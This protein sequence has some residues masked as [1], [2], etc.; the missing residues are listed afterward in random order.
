VQ[1]AIIGLG[2]VGGSI[3]LALKRSG[4][5]GCEVVGYVRRPEVAPTALR[6]GLVDKVETS[7][8]D[9]VREAE[10]IVIATPVLTVK[11]ILSQI[12]DHLPHGCVVTDTASTK[13]DVMLWAEDLIPA[14]ADFIGGHPMAGKETH[15]IQ[16]A[17]ASLFQGC[18]YCLTPA[19]KASTRGIDKVVKMVEQLGA[20]PLFIDAEEHDYL[21]AGISHLPM[22]LSAALVSATTKEPSWDKM[23]KLAASGYRDVTRL[24]S[25]NPEVNAHICLTN[26]AAILHWVDRFGSE[27]E[28]YRRLVTMG[29]K[30]LEEALAKASKARDEWLS[31]TQ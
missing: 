29:D 26:T 11:E 13:L 14:R 24:A 27:L 3:G 6:L 7:V 17:E 25:G 10:I 5:P 8:E 1:V 12:A 23:S 22:L 20:T 2:L 4:Q 15:G 21:V 9:A 31:R 19:N 30:R 18:I 16:A 28:T